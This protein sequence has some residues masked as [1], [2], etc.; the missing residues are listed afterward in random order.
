MLGFP[1]ALSIPCH[2]QFQRYFPPPNYCCV[3]YIL[4]VSFTGDV[5]QIHT[6]IM[7]KFLEL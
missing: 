6:F 5:K 1:F 2:V 3:G 7:E 4:N